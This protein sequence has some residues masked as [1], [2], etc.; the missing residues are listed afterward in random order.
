[1]LRLEFVTG[2]EL[3]ATEWGGVGEYDYPDECRVSQK[4]SR[5]VC[6]GYSVDSPSTFDNAYI[7]L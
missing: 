4:S 2:R 6:G 3:H 7:L 5:L 1:M